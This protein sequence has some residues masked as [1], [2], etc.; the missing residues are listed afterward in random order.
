MNM[1]LSDAI[2]VNA[3]ARSSDSDM[4]PRGTVLGKLALSSFVSDTLF[5]L[6]DLIKSAIYQLFLHSSIPHSRHTVN[7][8]SP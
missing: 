1:A 8:V 7:S 3:F 4:Y 6:S 2:N 5:A